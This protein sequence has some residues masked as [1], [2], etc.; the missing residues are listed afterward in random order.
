MLAM[1]Y[2]VAV[3]GNERMLNDICRFWEDSTQEEK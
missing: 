2:Y 3:R 1:E